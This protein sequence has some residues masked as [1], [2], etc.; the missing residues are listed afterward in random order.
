MA[1][2]IMTSKEFVKRLRI[3]AA[4]NTY[5]SATYPYN[6]C[7]IHPDGRTSAD[8]WNLIKAILNGYDVTKN[9]VKYYQHDLSNTGD[10]D[11]IGLLNKC[12]DVS[13]DFSKLKNGEPRY[14]YLKGTKVDHAGAYVGEFEVDGKT[15]NVIESTSS[16]E[17]KVLFSWVDSDG[18]RRHWK[19]ATKNGKWTKHGLMTPWVDYSD[20]AVGSSSGATVDTNT[21][22]VVSKPPVTTG[23]TSVK[24]TNE[25]IAK[26]VIVGKWGNGAERRNRLTAAG[27]DYS[28]VQHIVNEMCQSG[29][30]SVNNPPTENNE[31]SNT[32]SNYYIVKKGDTLSE[33]AVRFHTTQLKLLQL[34]PQ[35][36]NKDKIYIDQKIRVK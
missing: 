29:N 22:A 31:D 4:R 33:I 1:K 15:Y 20:A 36:K 23:E 14:L 19:G 3:I 11:G 34:N 12:S 24:K 2:I 27:Y 10:V 21:G 13:G 26:E 25:E 32:K 5:Y 9:Q 7:Y 8:C 16:W 28:A 35:I 6:C 17:H 30:H 18:T